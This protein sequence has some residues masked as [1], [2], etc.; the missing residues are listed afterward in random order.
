MLKADVVRL[1]GSDMPFSTA[2]IV[3]AGYSKDGVHTTVKGARVLGKYI[4]EQV[5]QILNKQK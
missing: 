5:L 3:Q 1:D 2:N 4:Y